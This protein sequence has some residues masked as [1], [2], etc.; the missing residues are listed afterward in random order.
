MPPVRFAL[1]R[2][3][4]KGR[5]SSMISRR[6]S[7]P[8]NAEPSSLFGGVMQLIW[9]LRNAWDPVAATITKRLAGSCFVF[10][11]SH[12]SLNTLREIPAPTP[13]QSYTI[14]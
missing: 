3:F 6:L 10:T 14:S 5:K 13:S 4:L 9:L 11:Q 2:S 7:L 1:I 8:M 12:I